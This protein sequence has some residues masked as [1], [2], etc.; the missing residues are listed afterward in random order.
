LRAKPECLICVLKQVL[1]TAGKVTEDLRIHQRLVSRAMSALAS[2][3]L[4]ITPAELTSDMFRLCCRELGIDD[5]FRAEMDRYNE[6]GLSLY[7]KIQVIL[8]NSGDRVFSAIL[9]AVAGN[10]ID[11][12]IIAEVDVEKAIFQV[13][14][15]G[16]KINDYRE[17]EMDLA[18][19]RELLYVL[20]NAGEI[21]FDKVLIEEIRKR[22][23]EIRLKIAVKQEPALNDALLIDAEKVG[24]DQLGQIIDTGCGDL[25]I[26]KNRCSPEFWE[27]LTGAD[28]VIAKGHANYETFEDKHPAFYAILRAKCSLVA[29]NLGVEVHDSVLKKIR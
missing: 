19:C 28:L 3:D 22:Y 11:L 27:Y 23:P 14:E 25:G 20:D 4:D 17:L 26:P 15:D 21:V 7:P 8:S 1:T 24:L 2:H 9:L 29:H 13:L 10:L 6:Q 16:L 12:G 18:D 5:P